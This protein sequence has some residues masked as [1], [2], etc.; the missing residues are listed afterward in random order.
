[1]I[2]TIKIGEPF[3]ADALQI[4]V[5][6]DA[7][8]VQYTLEQWNTVYD[9]GWMTSHPPV[10]PNGRCFTRYKTRRGAINFL[11]RLIANEA[12]VKKQKLSHGPYIG[13]Y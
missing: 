3:P 10:L 12:H 13:P 1:M 7:G 4:V 9:D 5:V 11:N 2:H 8:D 6:D